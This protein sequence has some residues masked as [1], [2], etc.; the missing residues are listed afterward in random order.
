MHASEETRTDPGAPDSA[1]PAAPGKPDEGKEREGR[2]GVGGGDETVVRIQLA[3]R[4]AEAFAPA[5]GDSLHATMQRFR[6]AYEYIDAVTHGVE[7][8]SGDTSGF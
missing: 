5:R 8:A 2:I 1:T 6:Q 3:A 4:W 7:P